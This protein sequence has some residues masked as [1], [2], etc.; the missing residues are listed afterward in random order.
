MTDILADVSGQRRPRD[1]TSEADIVSPLFQH[2]S[3]Y[4]PPMSVQLAHVRANVGGWR[5]H[6]CRLVGPMLVA[7]IDL[8]VGKLHQ[9]CQWPTSADI[10]WHSVCYP[11]V[12]TIV[13][14]TI[15]ADRLI[16]QEC[17]HPVSHVYSVWSFILVGGIAA[18]SYVLAWGF[19]K[20]CL[21]TSFWWAQLS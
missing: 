13:E 1:P 3:Q 20:Y 5:W 14:V 16:R 8:S 21:W 6:E 17:T 4:Q 2:L 19:V 7:D 15:D 10:G 18:T 9:Q 12:C 11:S